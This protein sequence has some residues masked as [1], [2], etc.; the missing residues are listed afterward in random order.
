MILNIKGDIIDNATKELINLLRDWGYPIL[1]DSFENQ[2]RW[3]RCTCRTGDICEAP[4]A[5]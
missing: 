2:F 1:G 3:W 4:R 5:E